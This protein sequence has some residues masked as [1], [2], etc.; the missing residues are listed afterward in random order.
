LTD[1]STLF[2]RYH[3][4]RPGLPPHLAVFVGAVVTAGLLV[5][6]TAPPGAA[7]RVDAPGGVLVLLAALV[8]LCEHTAVGVGGGRSRT[9]V[10][11]APILAAAFLG[12]ALGCLATALAFAVSAK[13]K[14]RSPL[15]RM[16][17][18]FG[19]ALLAAAAA[20][21][22]LRLVAPAPLAGAGLARAL[23]A[24][25]LAGLAYY[26][27]NHLLLSAVRG[28]AERRRPWSVWAADYRG[29]WPYYAVL[30]PLGLGAVAG[31]GALGAAGLA[32][33][34][35][36]ATLVHLA[37]TRYARRAATGRAS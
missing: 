32:A 19:N 10:A 15:H 17:F 1:L 37:I 8:V 24:A 12:G 4:G 5:L 29:L 2:G 23:P 7:A 18:N 21:W 13:V 3:H 27:V 26:A 31:Y 34:V 33:L 11:V 35:L 22:V 28:L 16:L 20:G 30:G 6:L 36:P 9:S 25:V 14:A